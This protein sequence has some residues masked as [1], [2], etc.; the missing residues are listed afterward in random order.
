MTQLG[1]CQQNSDRR[2]AVAAL[3][4]FLNG[5]L[6]TG[7]PSSS[8]GGLQTEDGFIKKADAGAAS[9]MLP[10]FLRSFG[11]VASPFF[12]TSQWPPRLVSSTAAQA[13]DK[14][15]PDCATSS[16]HGQDDTRCQTSVGPP[17]P[18][19]DK[20]TDPWENQPLMD[21]SA[22]CLPA[23]VSDAPSGDRLYPDEALMSVLPAHRDPL[24]ASSVSPSSRIPPQFSQPPQAC[25]LSTA[26][27][28]RFAAVLPILL[29]FQGFSWSLRTSQSALLMEI[30]TI[31]R[32]RNST[33]QLRQQS[34]CRAQ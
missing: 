32:H 8:S 30:P 31:T 17:G 1:R 11:Y 9:T 20:S 14:S 5:S 23:C 29:R 24:P 3:G 26:T 21:L 12:A 22:E 18:L 10:P 4:H 27:F 25:N 2:E 19:D 6:A 34:Q 28:H 7:R 16:R 33:H 15:S 13:S